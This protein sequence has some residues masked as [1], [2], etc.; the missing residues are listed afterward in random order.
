MQ[1]A[2]YAPSS[3]KLARPDGAF[4]VILQWVTRS[5]PDYSRTACPPT[6]PATIDRTTALAKY[7]K[8]CV[9]SRG[10]VR[11]AIMSRTIQF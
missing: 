5:E 7:G 11:Q 9:N 8:W 2:G 10:S 6:R 1:F 4:V 3:K